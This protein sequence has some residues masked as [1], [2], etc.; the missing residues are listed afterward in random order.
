[1]VAPSAAQ[2]EVQRLYSW[3]V[4]RSH[5]NDTTDHSRAIRKS[6]L[7]VGTDIKASLSDCSSITE[8][9]AI[10]GKA[11]SYVINGAVNNYTSN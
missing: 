7:S 5:H 9:F 4:T 2:N 6:G 10:R 11:S 1:M 8:S 3:A